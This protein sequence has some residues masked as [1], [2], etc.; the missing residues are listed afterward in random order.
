M[1]TIT[2]A[3]VVHR[4]EKRLKLMFAYDSELAKRIKMLN[5]CQWSQTL[6]CWH[7]PWQDNIESHIST[8]LNGG[9]KITSQKSISDQGL[10]S[11]QPKKKQIPAEYR[12]LLERRRYSASTI[13]TYTHFFTEFINYFSD[14]EPEEITEEDIKRYLDYKVSKKKVSCSTQN[15]IVNAIKFYYEKVLGLEKKEYWIDRPI[16]EA[17]LPLVITENEVLNILQTTHNLKHKSMIALLYSAGLRV[18]ELLNLR[19]ID[20]VFD[21]KVIFVRQGKGKKDRM[22]ILSYHTE[23]VLHRYLNK[24]MPKYWLFEGQSGG[25][26]SRESVNRFIRKWCLRAGIEKPVRSHTF[27][28]SFATHLLEQGTDIRYIQT[29]LGHSS[30]KTTAIYT[31]V[32]KRSLENIK[33]PLDRILEDNEV[34]NNKLKK[35]QLQ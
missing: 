2:I 11:N 18:G 30:P 9:A 17:H 3:P 15:Q 25:K 7:I 24:Y 10:F 8:I 31:H 12:N 28:H 29:L 23:I 19:K 34:N 1:K 4:N 5:N 6:R 21:K 33:S 32:S 35:E 27:R 26:Y 14:T 20:I 13:N 16:K 22:T